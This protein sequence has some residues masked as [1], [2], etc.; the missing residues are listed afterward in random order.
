M[1][2]SA[3][4]CSV[5]SAA[6]SASLE[7]LLR[8]KDMLSSR[9]LDPELAEPS[10]CRAR[11][12]RSSAE[13][14]S[15]D[16]SAAEET[17]G[18]R[19][20]AV[21]PPMVE[22]ASVSARSRS[23]SAM[24]PRVRSDA[25]ESSDRVGEEEPKGAARKSAPSEADDGAGDRAER[26]LPLEDGDSA[27]SREAEVR[28][29]RDADRSSGVRTRRGASDGSDGSSLGDGR[30]AGSEARTGED[31]AAGSE[32][33]TLDDAADAGGPKGSARS[34]ERLEALISSAAAES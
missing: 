20:G 30:G 3:T 22:M 4:S 23:R 9:V 10:D 13:R 15:R 25:A 16:C 11:L 2:A 33:R 14:L 8:A 17:L 12:S 7:S 28:T 34:P 26:A 29:L 27:E 32:V 24:R 21:L 31:A 18:A 19:E 6:C 1:A 5:S